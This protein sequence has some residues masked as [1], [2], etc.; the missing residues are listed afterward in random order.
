MNKHRHTIGFP[1][2]L[3]VFPDDILRGRKNLAYALMKG[4]LLCK[5]LSR[6]CSFGLKYFSGKFKLKLQIHQQ[7][8]AT[9]KFNYKHKQLNENFLKMSLQIVIPKKYYVSKGMDDQISMES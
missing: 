9:C 4:L 3:A 1:A 7:G 5:T 8:Q 6:N 2:Q